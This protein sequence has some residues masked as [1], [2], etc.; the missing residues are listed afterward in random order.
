MEMK[1]KEVAE[2]FGIS[3]RTLHH[4]DKIGLLTPSEVTDN[5]YRL[6]SEENL[7]TLQQIL[8]FRELGFPLKEIQKMMHNPSFNKKEAFMLQR[9]MLIEK[10]DNLNKMIGNIDKTLQHLTGETQYTYKERFENM[11]M[12]FSQYEEEAR[13]RWGNQAVDEV[14]S[15]LNHLSKDEQIELSDSWDSILNKLASLRSHS[16][17]SK[18]V[19]IVIKQWY[20][21]LNENFRYYSL[22]AFYGLGQLYI[23]DE[24]FKKNIDRYGDGLASFMS[25]AMKVF[26]TLHKRGNSFENDD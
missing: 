5:R 8:F 11:N 10:R 2:L 15:K 20:D 3:I 26:T 23:Q 9:K 6:Y 21:F 7:E 14:S 12:K 18:E 22:D 13:H 16:P 17:K 4:Y 24:R 19:Q 25:E 1:V